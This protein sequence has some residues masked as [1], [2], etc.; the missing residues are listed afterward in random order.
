[1][2]NEMNGMR[3]SQ[4]E[5]TM[6]GGCN[7]AMEGRMRARWANVTVEVQL[8]LNNDS[9]DECKGKRVAPGLMNVG[10]LA[11]ACLKERKRRMMSG[12]ESKRKAAAQQAS[13]RVLGSVFL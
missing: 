10:Y 8:H 2:T 5:M 1:M 9:L 13:V 3:R 6:M 7:V 11:K 4:V 12:L